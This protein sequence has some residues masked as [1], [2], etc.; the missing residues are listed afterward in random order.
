MATAKTWAE[1][2]FREYLNITEVRK[3]D[4]KAQQYDLSDLRHKS[5]FIKDILCMA[6]A[7]VGDCF[8]FLGVKS[9]KGKSRKVCGI[10]SHQDSSDLEQ[11]VAGV[12]E[13][14]IHF[15]YYSL[16]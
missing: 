11:I 14:P 10:D 6:N 12:I 5:L 3:V 8:I 15:D 2:V 9:D 4:Y 13:E 16:T 1:Q 7:P